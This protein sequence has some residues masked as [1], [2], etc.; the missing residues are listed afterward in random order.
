M[1]ERYELCIIGAGTAG[2]AAAEAGAAAGRRVAI[3]SGPGALGGTCILRG[4]MPAK[5]LLSSTERLGEVDSAAAVGVDVE[6]ARVDLPAIIERKRE[7]VDYFA[8]DRLDD[9]ERFPLLR[10]C[11]RFTAPGTIEAD[12]ARITAERFILAT[13]SRI[14]APAIP[15]LAEAGYLTSDDVLEMK[16]IPAGIAVIGAG[17][18]GCEFAQYFA[19]L[20]ASV[21]LLQ[22]APHVLRNEDADVADAVAAALRADGVE[23]VLDARVEHCVKSGTQTI[24]R[25][26][27]G[28]LAGAVHAEAV[29]LAAG[30]V[31]NFA[32]LQLDAAGVLCGGGKLAV[33]PYLRTT[34]PHILAAG[35]VLGRR[36]LVHVAAYA[37]KLAAHNAFAEHPRKADF[38]R[39]EMHAVYTQPQVAVA[40]LTERE[41]LARGRNVRVKHHPFSDLGKALVSNEATG[42]IKM[43]AGEGGRIVGVAVVGND[44]IDLIGEAAAFI[45]HGATVRDVADMPHLHPTMGEIFGRVAEE[46]AA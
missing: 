16:S 27:S 12:G 28:G 36:C 4:C 37:G 40:G 35:D 2:F 38:D 42:F 3:V 46:L 20:G 9:L 29:L 24:V 43:I 13:G 33:D 31:P 41:C 39:F 34:N 15:G 10:G 17:P 14:V 11:A 22:D 30:R 26:T 32:G 8:Q 21:T 45:D 44:A 23:L 19:R 25:Y 18:V 7:L 6:R 1:D 5:T